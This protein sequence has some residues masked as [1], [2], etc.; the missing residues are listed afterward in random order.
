M[1]ETNFNWH[2][3]NKTHLYYY[4]PNDNHYHTMYVEKTLVTQDNYAT[5]KTPSLANR[6]IIQPASIQKITHI[7][8]NIMFNNFEIWHKKEV[9]NQQNMMKKLVFLLI[10]IM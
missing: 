8:C 5:N 6:W 10:Y 4:Y 7:T 1:R 9:I 2:F 3:C